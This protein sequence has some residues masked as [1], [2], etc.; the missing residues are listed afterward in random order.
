MLNATFRCHQDHGDAESPEVRIFRSA[1]NA[2]GNLSSKQKMVSKRVT[3]APVRDRS[4]N[5]VNPPIAT[6]R[7]CKKKQKIR[8]I[9]D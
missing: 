4:L 7:S 5:I 1:R 9:A 6:E 3:A 2:S 8:K